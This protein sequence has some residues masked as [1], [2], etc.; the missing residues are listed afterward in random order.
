MSHR[1]VVDEK[2]D[3][4]YN[5]NVRCPYCRARI[6]KY[7]TTCE[8]CG[9][10]KKQILNASNARAKEIKKQKTGGK[11]VFTRNRPSDVSFTR[12]VLCLLL[13]LFGVHN[14]YVGRKIRGWVMLGGILIVIA[15]FFIFPASR[16]GELH[17]VNALFVDN[18][19]ESPF[20]L[21]GAAV[22]VMWAYDMFSIVFG[23][24]KY[25]VR[26]GE[27]TEKDIKN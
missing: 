17:P 2:L 9:I 27:K 8:R 26:L 13:G 3:R 25:P 22:F 14:F 24:Y 23:F 10:T 5:K 6:H 7:T 12:L 15:S 20:F 21:L 19:M 11:I 16:D 1:I 18:G 4:L